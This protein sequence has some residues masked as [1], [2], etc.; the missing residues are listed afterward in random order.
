MPG[1]GD[2][3]V[4]DLSG[5][6]TPEQLSPLDTRCHTVQFGD[7][8]EEPLGDQDFRKLAGFLKKYPKVTLRVYG[9]GSPPRDLDFLR[10]FPFVKRLA[11][12]KYQ[13]EDMSGIAFA[14]PDLEELTLGQTR[15]KRHSLKFLERFPKLRKLYL[16]GH[17]KDIEIV[18]CLMKLQDLT[19][20]SITLSDLRIL[21][22]LRA[23]ESLAIKLG[24]TRDL[25]LLPGIGKLR[26]L[27]L[28]QV[29]GLDDLSR[30]PG[31]RT[32]QYLF[33]QALKRVSELPS[34][35]NLGTLPRVHLETMKG[36]KDLRPVVKAPALEELL[37]IDMPH[38]EPNAFRP[39][40]GHRT[41]R[42]IC[43]DLGSA[44][45]SSTKNEVV[46]QLLGLPTFDRSAG[47]QFRKRK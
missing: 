21:K 17:N 11:I 20:R 8:V 9:W 22:P 31:I 40:I 19:L 6:L 39:F 33:L 46:K 29:L 7:P 16:E 47:F 42:R 12:E 36:V 13:L 24:G 28:W 18:S 25:G 27:E 1:F 3:F 35:A 10:F 37:V 44:G 26:Y 15:S 45:R 38:L 2:P 4:R 14:C 34:F 43:L 5:P 41:L 32:L 30:I 23:L